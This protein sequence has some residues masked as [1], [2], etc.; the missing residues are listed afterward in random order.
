MVILDNMPVPPYVTCAHVWQPDACEGLPD[1]TR[2][3]IATDLCLRLRRVAS[4]AWG[5]GQS[6]HSSCLLTGAGVRPLHGNQ[7]EAMRERERR[8]G[9]G[10]DMKEDRREA[11]GCGRRPPPVG[12][13][14][15]GPCRAG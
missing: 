6:A 1:V 9:R 3:R 4:V 5:M 15:R 12:G 14:A 8:G 7:C 2:R 11:E 10:G 13:R